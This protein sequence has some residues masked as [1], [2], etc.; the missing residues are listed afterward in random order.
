M[1]AKLIA[2]YTEPENP[3]EFDKLY[4]ET[5]LPLVEKLPGL[6]RMEVS[7]IKSNMMGGPSPYYIIAELTFDSVEAL[8][9]AMS[10]PQ[11]KEAGKNIM[12]F[13]AK[14]V[15]MLVSEVQSAVGAG[16]Y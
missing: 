1:S 7:K 9:S 8:N 11:G 12:S 2:L 6:A 13:A 10:S 15:T 4:F 5:H 14:N 3:K 16:A